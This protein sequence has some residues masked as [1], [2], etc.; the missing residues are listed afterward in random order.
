[1]YIRINLYEARHVVFDPV[2][3]DLWN[4]GLR[5]FSSRVSIL[6]CRSAQVMDGVLK[7]LRWFSGGARAPCECQDKDA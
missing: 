2:K 5:G 4:H 1:M 3:E 7:N 6:S